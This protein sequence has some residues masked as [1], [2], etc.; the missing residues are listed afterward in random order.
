MHGLT[1]HCSYSCVSYSY[2]VAHPHT[3]EKIYNILP[4]KGLVT[5][6]TWVNGSLWLSN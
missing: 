3:Q 4:S 1:G 6:S 2:W 5:S